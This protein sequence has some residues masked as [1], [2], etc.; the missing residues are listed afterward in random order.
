VNF[1]GFDRELRWL[2][3]GLGANG[4]VRAGERLDAGVPGLRLAVE[5]LRA[6]IRDAI[7][8]AAGASRAREAGVLAALAIGDQAAIEPALWATYAATGVGH[9][10]SISGLHVTMLAGLG[11]TVA[12]WV[13]RRP[14][15]AR[16]GGPIAVPTPTLRLGVAVAVAFG[17]AFLAGWGVPAQRTCLMLA[18]AAALVATGR[19]AS[20]GAAVGVAAAAIVVLDP[21]APLAAGFWLSFGAVLAIVWACAGERHGEGRTARAVRGALRTQWAATV[22]LLPLGAWWFGTVSVAGPLAN[23]VA[24]PLVSGVVTPLALAGGALALASPGVGAFAVVPAA[25]LLAALNAVLDAV[26]AWPAAAVPLPRPG[27]AAV[28]VACA[29]CV[30]LLAPRGVPWRGAG[31]AALA[32]LA[33]APVARPS[34][35]ELWLTALD[36]GQGMAVV[37]Q[38]GG[39]ALVY[40]TGPSS[41]PAA[42]AG[43]RVIVP[44]LR[45]EGIARPDAVV[46][47]HADDDHAG[48]A[49][50]LL[51]T[52]PPDWLASSLPDGHPVA[53]AAPR[54]LRCRRGQRWTWGAAEFEFLHP[55]DPQEPSRGSRSNAASCVLRIRT[56][57]GTALLAGDIEAAQERRLLELY[58]DSG[59]AADV[60]LVPH[61]G[62][63]TSSTEGFVAAVA[64]SW[65][66]VQAAYRSRFGHPHPTVLARYA[67]HGAQVLRSDADGAVRIRLAPG[68]PARVERARQS[69]ARYWRVEVE[70]P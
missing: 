10:M 23:A 3:D 37:V 62:S 29:G 12:G 35:H 42:D 28:A 68:A 38:A 21:W 53:A 41:G 45:G 25:T 8:D 55:A 56:P 61:H 50:S 14:A 40:D 5:R 31:A 26:A 22:A 16:R 44:W 69:P 59:L 64:P 48:G 15:V 24:I 43:A 49:R 32:P 13:W 63:R 60:L 9:L 18:V 66:I 51:R 65:A 52:M 11:G 54:A 58:G 39:R 67:R 27:L 34:A 36:V 47:S 57:A 70:P 20:I 7:F 4:S 1:G 2:E 6:T 46:V 19:C 30:L 17:Y 33:F